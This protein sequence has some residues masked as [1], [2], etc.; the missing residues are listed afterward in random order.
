MVCLVY[1]DGL[2]VVGRKLVQPF[3]PAHGLDGAYR[4]GKEP[5]QVRLPRLL[6]S[7][8]EPGK[9]QELVLRL[10]QEL[11]PV[12]KLKHLLPHLHLV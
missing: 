3:L 4:H 1:D 11:I 6:Q 2:E 8:M 5:V 10:G 9:F 12:R 7:C